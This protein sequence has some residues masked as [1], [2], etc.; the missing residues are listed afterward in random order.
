MTKLDA[1]CSSLAQMAPLALA[2]SWDNVGLL[3]GRRS[4]E[5][6]QVMTCLTITPEVVQEAIGRSVG[7][8]VT[9]HPLPFQPLKKITSDSSTG[10]MLL[11]LIGAGVAVYSAHTAFDSAEQGINQSWVNRLGLQH[12][13]PLVAADEDAANPLGS[14]RYG[15]LP[16]AMPLSDLVHRAARWVPADS[17]RFVGDPAA[18]TKRVASA[19]GS[20]GSFLA[21]ADRLGCD[22]MITGEATFHTCLDAKARGLALILIGHYHSER[23]AMERLADSLA[24]Q[25]ADLAVWASRAETDPIRSFPSLVP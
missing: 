12:S 9:H 2:E 6:D 14:G 7:L 19:C 23:F 24:A 8:I 4:A 16:A 13:R 17:I 11:S 15:E 10:Q 18:T 3:V 25:H 5:V 21:D 1:L 22:A 20:G